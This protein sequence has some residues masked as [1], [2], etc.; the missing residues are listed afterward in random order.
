MHVFRDYF[1]VS[2]TI[3]KRR[4]RKA[5][6]KV[7]PLRDNDPRIKRQKAQK[8]KDLEERMEGRENRTGEKN[9]R[10]KV[11]AKSCC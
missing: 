9:R 1:S 5:C 3:F 8:K 2:S 11:K 6:S 4:K 7:K 10:E